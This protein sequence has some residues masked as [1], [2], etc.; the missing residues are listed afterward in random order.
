M[1]L[2]AGERDFRALERRALRRLKQAGL[3]P[4]YVEIREAGTLQ[5]PSARARR[6][7]VLAAAWLGRARLI[8]NIAVNLP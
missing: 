3:R 5:A 6:L 7:R 8:D 4:E 1:G 2:L